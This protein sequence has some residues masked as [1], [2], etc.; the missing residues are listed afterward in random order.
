MSGRIGRL[1]ERVRTRL[2]L[3]A[4][5]RDWRRQCADLR[6]ATIPAPARRMLICD[7]LTT[8]AGSKVETI[9]AQ[10]MRCRGYEVDVLVDGRSRPVRD[11]FDGGG[12]VRFVDWND[13][14]T[15]DLL[16][17]GEAEADRLLAGVQRAADLLE[18]AHGPVRTGRNAISTVVRRLRQGDVDLADPAEAA[19]TR[20]LLGR[21][22]AAGL[23]AQRL[24]QANGYDL[25]LFNVRGYTPAGEVFDACV[26]AGVDAVQWVGAPQADHFLFKRY[27]M[28]NRDQHPLALGD[29]TW[30]WLSRVPWTAELDD[31][32]TGLFDRNYQSGAWFNR[33]QLHVGKQVRARDDICRQLRLDPGRPIAVIFAHILYDATFFYGTSLF[34]NYRV[35]LVETV[36]AAIANPRLNWVVKVHPVNVWRS[37]MDGQPMEQLEAVALGEAFGELPDHVRIMPADTDISTYS[38][39]GAIDYGLTVRGT[40]G[41]ELP[42]FGI[43]TVTAGTGRY[44]HRGFTLDPESPA[45][46]H[47]LLLRLH[48]VPRLDDATVELARRYAYGT[49]FLRPYPIDYFRLDFNVAAPAT[50]SLAQ[51]TS[52]A[53]TAPGSFAAAA[54]IA[55]IADWMA[56]SG[57]ADLLN[58][59]SPDV[60]AAAAAGT[61]PA[62][63]ARRTG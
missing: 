16:A 59:R 45:A 3:E 34:E 5:R 22:I 21:S 7:L 18:V 52:I 42:C 31:G 8:L 4:D 60:A 56:A 55:A 35:W 63:L 1:A 33:Q 41:M 37:R 17:Q 27:D 40:I 32:L 62:N 51:N 49:F 25:A 36:R 28:G 20:E 48:E 58:D 14:L 24:V 47:A 54:D 19:L 39:F 57:N 61:L 6:A 30:D 13:W 44:S 23:A 15:P 2:A 38:L 12:R 11:V 29:E 10:A 46:F 43:P 50:P 9:L 26:G 53:R